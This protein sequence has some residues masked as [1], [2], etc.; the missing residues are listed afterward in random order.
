[1]W[2]SDGPYETFRDRFREG[3][4]ARRNLLPGYGTSNSVTRLDS[5]AGSPF[6]LSIA[7]VPREAFVTGILEYL[8]AN[9]VLLI[10]ILLGVA[11][12]VYS[13]LK[14]LLKIAA[15]LAIAGALYVVLVRYLDGGL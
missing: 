9:P 3:V 2:G 8:L 6:L 13:L 7:P 4:A 5:P 12:I 10:P 11:M 15:L 1:M 14:K